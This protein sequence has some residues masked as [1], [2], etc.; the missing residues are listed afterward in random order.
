V[1]PNPKYKMNQEK[2]R[3]SKN[4]AFFIEPLLSLDFTFAAVLGFGG[5]SFTWYNT[6][7][8][9]AEIIV[10]LSI[11]AILGVLIQ[12]LVHL[13]QR[14]RYRAPVE[15]PELQMLLDRAA[16]RMGY[17]KDFEVWMNNDQTL[18][19][20]SLSNF[21]SRAI[22]VSETVV[23]DIL[24]RPVEG[25]IVLA[26]AISEF[27]SH[28]SLN[29]WIPVLFIVGIQIPFIWWF[30]TPLSLKIP[31]AVLIVTAWTCA[32][33]WSE[34]RGTRSKPNP[35]LQEYGLSPDEASIL[36]FRALPPTEA[37]A[38]EI[39]KRSRHPF[40][41][42][43]GSGRQKA[44]YLSASLAVSIAIAFLLYQFVFLGRSPAFLVDM[45]LDVLI[46]LLVYIVIFEVGIHVFSKRVVI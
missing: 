37:E 34:V 35:A 17:E 24:A 4:K 44:L 7:P 46:S 29:T 38:S 31:F 15:I 25:E 40:Y 13:F 9:L 22:V 3:E 33:I 16:R 2:S 12:V 6:Q 26:N 8:G 21:L 30:S 19:L 20:I 42:P 1:S 14:R 18:L 43:A 41:V 27:S 28:Y 23:Q 5:F 32:S 39:R 11:A 10:A 36:V 45:G